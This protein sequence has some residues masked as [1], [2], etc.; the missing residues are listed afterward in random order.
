V[1]VKKVFEDHRKE[2][3][4]ECRSII[5]G[6]MVLKLNEVLYLKK[7]LAVKQTIV[8]YILEHHDY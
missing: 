2:M 4:E 5:G 8:E 3:Y 7:P 1:S 6:T